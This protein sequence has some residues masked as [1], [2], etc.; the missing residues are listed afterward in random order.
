[1]TGQPKKR[2]SRQKANRR[3]YKIYYGKQCVSSTSYI[4][5]NEIINAAK[6]EY[7]LLSL[8]ELM[9]RIGKKNPDA[10]IRVQDMMEKRQRRM[11]VGIKKVMD[12]QS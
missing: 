4:L 5:L 3:A 2:S 11:V 7:G 10:T 9:D 12:V 1:M 6:S 8:H